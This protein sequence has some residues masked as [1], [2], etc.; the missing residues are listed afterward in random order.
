LGKHSE[1]YW[2]MKN[3]IKNYLVSVIIPNWDGLELL[4]IC[5]PS[6]KKQ[7]YK[8]YEVIIVDNGSVDDSIAWINKNFSEF[9]TLKLDKNYGFARAVNKGIKKSKG[10]YI[11]LLNNDTEVDKRCVEFLVESANKNSEL[12]FISAKILNY[13]NRKI[14]DNAGDYLDSS[15]HL[16]TYGLGQKDGPVFNEGRFIF[17]GTGGG[18]LFTREVFKKI[19][20]FDED[21]YFYMEDADFCLRAQLAS[22]KGWFEPKA[23]IYHRRMATS[24]RLKDRDVL[25]FQNMIVMVIKNF[26]GFL[27]L[28]RFNWLRILLV[29]INTL[30]Y[31]IFKGHIL[32]VLKAELYLIANMAGILKKR[33][34]IQKLKTVP[35]DYIVEN[36]ME[37]QFRAGR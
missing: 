21:F 35:D 14:I 11:F 5:L 23:K 26:P 4:K 32:G 10:E 15:G 18:T 7:T 25:V 12:G 6:I 27:L 19:G 22:F 28:H 29:H 24:K 1:F 30:R 9:I 20:F 16:L 2:I 8:N 17:L 33:A 3:A 37:K 34:K 13:E 36:I 31:L